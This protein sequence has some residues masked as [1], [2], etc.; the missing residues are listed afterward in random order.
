MAEEVFNQLPPAF[1]SEGLV[2]RQPNR[3][4]AMPGQIVPAN[5]VS[6]RGGSRWHTIERNLDNRRPE[7]AQRDR[8]LSLD[9]QLTDL[10]DFSRMGNNDNLR[11]G[12]QARRAGDPPR[13]SKKMMLKKF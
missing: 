12:Y 5:R 4:N 8:F 3:Q 10:F 11:G 1:F 2:H 7:V 6:S 9:S 13:E